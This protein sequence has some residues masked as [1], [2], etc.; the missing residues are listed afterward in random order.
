MAERQWEARALELARSVLGRTRP[1]PAVGAVLVRDDTVVGEGATQPPG[2]PHAEIMALRAAGERAR[3]ATLYVTLEPCCHHGRTPPCTDAI[4]AAGVAEVRYAI[5]DPNPQVAG[6]GDYLL[7]SAGIRVLPGDGWWAE[8]AR[9]LNEA[10]FHWVRTGRPFVVAKWAMSLDGRIATHRGDSR[11][12]TGEEARHRVH[13]VRNVTDAILI[14]S[15]TAL[16]DDPALTTRLKTGEVHHPLR[17]VPDARGR[18]PVTAR[19]VAGG[20][21]GRTLVATTA[22]SPPTWRAELA[23]GGVEVLVLPAGTGR[24]VDLVTLLDLLGQRDITSVLVEGGATVLGAFVEAGLV[25]KYLVFVAPVVIGGAAAP[26]PVGGTGAALLAHALRLHLDRIEH[27]GRDVLLTCY[28]RHAAD[29]PEATVP[30]MVKVE[31]SGQG[32]IPDRR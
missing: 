18:L 22:S 28:P 11:W 20:L 24:G 25:D 6:R 5:G 31:P 14:G 29:L 1:R 10:F 32:V 21:P 23:A 19:L 3:G 30:G 16:A 8:E 17:I 2:G 7:R 26:G 9:R 27:I 12:I 13:Q 15:G 4:K